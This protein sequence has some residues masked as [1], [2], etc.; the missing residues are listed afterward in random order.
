MNDNYTAPH[1]PIERPWTWGEIAM[2]AFG[3]AILLYMA[4]SMVIHAAPG[5]WRL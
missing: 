4:D 2:C 3:I 5:Y 1:M